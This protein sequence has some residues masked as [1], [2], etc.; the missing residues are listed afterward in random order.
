M[1]SVLEQVQKKL[2]LLGGSVYEYTE[3]SKEDEYFDIDENSLWIT[4]PKEHK[5]FFILENI[6]IN[7]TLKSVVIETENGFCTI[8]YILDSGVLRLTLGMSF[9]PIDMVKEVPV[10]LIGYLRILCSKKASIKINL[11][12]DKILV[13]FE[14][15]VVKDKEAPK[16]KLKKGEKREAP[17]G[18]RY[19]LE[20]PLI[21]ADVLDKQ[22]LDYIRDKTGNVY[23][24]L[25][26]KFPIGVNLDAFD[27]TENEYPL[28]YYEVTNEKGNFKVA[29]GVEP[30]VWYIECPTEIARNLPNESG[31]ELSRLIEYE[32]EFDYKEDFEGLNEITDRIDKFMIGE[33]DDTK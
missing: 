19:T 32:G 5:D 1:P 24:K 8:Y 17:I 13:H 21:E 25:S 30:S 16:V 26:K 31:I 7:K 10:S 15:T 20:L 11:L 6:G 29:Y 14:D 3:K 18:K 22:V 33:E 2:E 4:N 23:G 12:E 28:I 9:Q 27:K